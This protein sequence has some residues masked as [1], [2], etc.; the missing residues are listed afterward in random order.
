MTVSISN[1]GQFIKQAM[2][3]QDVTLPELSYGTHQSKQAISGYTTNRRPAP[4]DKVVSITDHLKDTSLNYQAAEQV[5]GILNLRRSDDLS[6]AEDPF[7]VRFVCDKEERERQEIESIVFDAMTA[8]YVRRT[9]EQ[10]N[11]I[12]CG[13]KELAEEI[14]AEL[15]YLNTI[16]QEERLNALEEIEKINQLRG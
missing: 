15:L 8:P 14:S 4:I 10:H 13:V 12:R 3:Q 6:H 9:K 5:F 1:L 2:K 7:M 11:Q 16:C